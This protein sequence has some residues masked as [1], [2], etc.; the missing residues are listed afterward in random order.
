MKEY[1]FRSRTVKR[2]FGRCDD[3]T[4]TTTHGMSGGVSTCKL[5]RCK[6]SEGARSPEVEGRP[7]RFGLPRLLVASTCKPRRVKL[8]R[9][10][11]AQV[12]CHL[13]ELG[14]SASGRATSPAFMASARAT[15][16]GQVVKPVAMPANQR[17]WL[18]CSNPAARPRRW[19]PHYR[20]DRNFNAS[21]AA[22]P[23]AVLSKMHQRSVPA[24]Q[25]LNS[26]ARA[27]SQSSL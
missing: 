24:G 12:V 21:D 25:P 13:P 9:R 26:L 20:P 16:D 23:E 27:S 2:Q 1:C 8:W 18:Q 22:E 15:A 7:R 5:P 19:S 4:K 14:P 3:R 10:S 11:R 17:S 6:Q